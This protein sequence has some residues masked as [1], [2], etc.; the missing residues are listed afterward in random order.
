M[1][2]VHQN[3]S[4]CAEDRL[5]ALA[6]AVGGLNKPAIDVYSNKKRSSTYSMNKPLDLPLGE[7][8]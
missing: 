2:N 5:L 4:G 8:C 7:C 1:V 6:Q 3:A